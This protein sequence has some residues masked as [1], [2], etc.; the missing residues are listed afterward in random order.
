[1]FIVAAA[2][3]SVIALVGAL[4][5]LKKTRRTLRSSPTIPTSPIA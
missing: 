3:I 4:I 2:T 5:D 1:M